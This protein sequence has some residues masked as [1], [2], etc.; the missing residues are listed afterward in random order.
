[1]KNNSWSPEKEV[2]P[3][4]GQRPRMEQIWDGFWADLGRI[5]VSDSVASPPGWKEFRLS[6]PKP[7]DPGGIL[8]QLPALFLLGISREFHLGSGESSPLIPWLIP[9]DDPRFLTPL[10]PLHFFPLIS[11]AT[12]VYAQVGPSQQVS[13]GFRV[14]SRVGDTPRTPQGHPGDTLGAAGQSPAPFGIPRGLCHS[15]RCPKGA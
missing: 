3:G 6:K 10:F 13:P 5:W 4:R 14:L 9:A 11:D 1:M 15:W 7:T 8:G 12:T 2:G